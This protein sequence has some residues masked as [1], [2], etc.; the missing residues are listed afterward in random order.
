MVVDEE[1]VEW[2]PILELAAE[3]GNKAGE[4]AARD[5]EIALGLA[6]R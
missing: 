6:M 5:L 4:E 1:E 2:L 3:V